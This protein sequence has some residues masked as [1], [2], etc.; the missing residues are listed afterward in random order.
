MVSC[1]ST[2]VLQKREKKTDHYQSLQDDLTEL[3]LAEIILVL[4]MITTIIVTGFLI[5]F[6]II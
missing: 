5:F 6:F 2:I 4:Q 1:I 3:F